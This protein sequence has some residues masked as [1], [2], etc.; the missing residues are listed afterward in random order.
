MAFQI[1]ANPE[2]P[3]KLTLVGQGREQE[4]NVVFKFK[5][6]DERKSMLAKLEKDDGK[7]PELIKD[8]LIS[9]DADLPLNLSSIKKL[10]ANQSGACLAIW[11]GYMYSL[12]VQRKGN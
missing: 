10:E 11:T 7:F 4:L 5:D 12:M 9:W 6:A 1:T 2:I 3:A 8:I